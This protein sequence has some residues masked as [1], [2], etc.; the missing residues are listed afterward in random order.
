MRNDINEFLNE[1]I[2]MVEEL[3]GELTDADK[4]ALKNDFFKKFENIASELHVDVN[5]I[6]NDFDLMIPIYESD[7]D[8]NTA[9]AVISGDY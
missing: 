6:L 1:Q 7:F 5:L 2:E 3:C 9:V 8:I 4:E